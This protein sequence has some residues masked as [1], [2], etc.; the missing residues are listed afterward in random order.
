MD[1]SPQALTALGSLLT[2]LSQKMAL[3]AVRIWELYIS[4][5]YNIAVLQTKRL[6]TQTE[7]APFF[8]LAVSGTAANS[9]SREWTKVLL[10]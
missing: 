3:L 4:S 2:D 8:P 10:Y 6:V 5:Q 9:Y 1:I 7:I